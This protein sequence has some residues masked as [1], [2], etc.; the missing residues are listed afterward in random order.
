MPFD[1][2]EVQVDGTTSLLADFPLQGS[3]PHRDGGDTEESAEY[4]VPV[5]WH[6]TKTKDQAFWKQGMFANQHSAC[7]LSNQFTIEQVSAFFGIED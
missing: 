2:A 4:I 3:C 6:S 1:R 5:D 7:R